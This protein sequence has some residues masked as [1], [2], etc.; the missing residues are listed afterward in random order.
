MEKL[1]RLMDPLLLGL[2]SSLLAQTKV[3]GTVMNDQ[4]MPISGANGVVLVL[5]PMSYFTV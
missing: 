4:G 1:Y 2:S 3:S 5:L